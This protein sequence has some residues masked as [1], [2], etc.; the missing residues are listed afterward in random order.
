M[1]K[2]RSPTPKSRRAKEKKKAQL[3][4]MENNSTRSNTSL[5]NFGTNGKHRQGD[6][7]AISPFQGI[8]NPKGN[9]E[10]NENKTMAVYLPNTK[11]KLYA[12][13]E[14]HKPDT[15]PRRDEYQILEEIEKQDIAAVLSPNLKSY[16]RTF[17][18]LIT[19]LL[20]QERYII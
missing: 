11:L 16:S 7:G 13:P 20:L 14:A 18:T 19:K 2:I 4:V 15:K 8:K 5:I 6:V 3:Y 17:P 9:P 1:R 10:R 12:Y